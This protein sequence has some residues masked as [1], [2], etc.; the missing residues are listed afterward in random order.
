MVSF[1]ACITRRRLPVSSRLTPLYTTFPDGLSSLRKIQAALIQSA[2]A[3]A[4]HASNKVSKIKGKYNFSKAAAAG[5]MQDV[6]PMC[7]LAYATRLC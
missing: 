4:L 5:K 6:A 3:P 1:T 2:T 7:I